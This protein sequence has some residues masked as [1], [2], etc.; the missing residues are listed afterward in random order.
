M[1]YFYIT[2]GVLLAP[3]IIFGLSWLILLI[4]L[5]VSYFFKRDIPYDSPRIRRTIFWIGTLLIKPWRFKYKVINKDY[6]PETDVV[7]FGNHISAFDPVVLCYELRHTAISGLAKKSLYEIPVFHRWLKAR[8]VIAMDRTNNRKDAEA[9]IRAIRQAKEGQP[10][11]VFPE[12][13]RSR[14]GELI[15][16]RPGSFRLATKSKKDIVVFKFTGMNKHKWYHLKRITCTLEF[17]PMIKYEDYKD[18]STQELSD[19]V[20]NIILEG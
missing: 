14:T 16:F 7:M 10:M 8:R 18:L 15:D 20:R 6:V 11:F 5:E 19:K 17:F 2:L 13:T 9:M 1:I 12:G 3:I 4:C